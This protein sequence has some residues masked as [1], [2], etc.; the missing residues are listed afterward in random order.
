MAGFHSVKDILEFAHGAA[1]VVVTDNTA[2]VSAIVDMQGL[3]NVTWAIITGT[4][5]DAA[6]T[7]T[8]SVAHGDAVDD[9]AAPTEITD[10]GA[11]PA[12]TL[13]PPVADASFDQ[14]DDNVVRTIAYSPMRGAGKRYARVT[15]TPAG[16]AGNAPLAIVAVKK[17]LSY[18]A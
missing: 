11:A 7:F 1:P 15:V 14:D 10:T 18:G 13:D 8:V 2:V 12:A 6:A 17:P 3:E 4:L 9:A 16:N 5:A